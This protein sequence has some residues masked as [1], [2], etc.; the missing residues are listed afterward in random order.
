MKRHGSLSKRLSVILCT[1]MLIGFLP[2]EIS[3]NQNIVDPDVSYLAQD[4]AE[5]YYETSSKQVISLLSKGDSVIV[6]DKGKEYSKVLLENG[7]SGYIKNELLT[8][9][10]KV[11]EDEDSQEATSRGLFRD[12]KIENKNSASLIS[13]AKGKLGSPYSYGSRG[14][15]KF[16]CSGFVGY[17]Y[18]KA[19]GIKLPRDSRAMSVTGISIGKSELK[20]GDLVFFHTGGGNRVSHVGIYIEDGNF[21]HASSGNVQKVIISNLNSGYYAKCYHSAKRVIK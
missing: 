9:S 7:Q 14:P 20:E 15:N 12:K 4:E 11:S 1:G 2:G 19:L 18:E 8:D 10:I 21:I 16:D 17:S 5:L 6:T 13:F 3:A